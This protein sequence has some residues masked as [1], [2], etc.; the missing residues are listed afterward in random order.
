MNKDQIFEKLPDHF[1]KYLKLIPERRKIGRNEKCPCGSGKKFKF[2]C[3]GKEWSEIDSKFYNRVIQFII[4]DIETEYPKNSFIIFE[5]GDPFLCVSYTYGEYFTKEW[6]LYFSR[7]NIEMDDEKFNDLISELHRFMDLTNEII[8]RSNIILNEDKSK[9]KEVEILFLA[10]KKE[11]ILRVLKSGEKIFPDI[12]FIQYKIIQQ[13]GQ[14]IHRFL[15]DKGYTSFYPKEVKREELE[16]ENYLKKFTKDR[17]KQFTIDLRSAQKFLIST[18]IASEVL[19]QCD[20]PIEKKVGLGMLEDNIPFIQQHKIYENYQK[21]D[22]NETYFTKAD[23]F[24]PDPFEPVAIYCDGFAYHG[25]IPEQLTHDRR[26]DRKLQELGIKVLRFVGTEIENNLERCIEDIKK[27]YLGNVFGKEP[28][29]I[30]L[31]KLSRI[32]PKSFVNN[33]WETNF[34]KNIIEWVKSGKRTTIKQEKVINKLYKKTKQYY[35]KKEKEKK[36]NT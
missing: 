4:K 22:E 18:N 33:E 20:S 31:R 9:I 1:K 3:L 19:K 13:I 28:R 11:L 34:Y 32:N 16:T 23:F 27:A 10:F 21:Q 2:C 36:L 14:Q 35:K 29:D 24:I 7:E 26:I 17:D 15:K 30:I 12:D 5:K 25:K 8:F 6:A